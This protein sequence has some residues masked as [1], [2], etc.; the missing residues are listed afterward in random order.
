MGG[1]VP[2]R[3]MIRLAL[4]TVVLALLATKAEAQI[5]GH[6]TGCVVG[7]TGIA[8]GNFFGPR[9]DSTGSITLVCEGNGNNNPYTVALSE[10]GSNT[11]LDRFM[12][13]GTA[14]LHYNLYVDAARTAI[15][16]NGLGETRLRSGQF[17]FPGGNPQTA[18]LPVFARIPFQTTPPGGSYIDHIIVTVTF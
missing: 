12:F 7:A 13:H 6:I 4:L 2:F 9:V 11:F 8:F 3:P 16:G 5:R 18:I 15:W 14:E 10:G 17:N 1:P